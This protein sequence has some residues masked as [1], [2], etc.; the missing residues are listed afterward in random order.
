M[1][2]EG[3][4]TWNSKLSLFIRAQLWFLFQLLQKVGSKPLFGA[5]FHLVVWLF[6]GITKLSWSFWHDVCVWVW[7]A[8]VCVWAG[9][10]VYMCVSVVCVYECICIC[11]CVCMWVWSI[12]KC[13]CMWQCLCV[14]VCMNLA[15]SV[16]LW[17]WCLCMH[18]NMCECVVCVPVYKWT[19]GVCHA[20]SAETVTVVLLSACRSLS[21]S[22]RCQ[23]SA[24][25]KGPSYLESSPDGSGHCASRQ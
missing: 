6:Q 13:M 25:L 16:Y 9:E 23:G 22:W 1:A 2:L 4:N 20:L 21:H 7:C 3:S 5:G 24:L 17:M 15:L 19:S 18:M 11:V 12:Y 8:C 14:F 10:C